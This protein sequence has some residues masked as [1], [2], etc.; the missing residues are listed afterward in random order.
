MEQKD[1]QMALPERKAPIHVFRE[2]G[3]TNDDAKRLAREGAVEG[4]T[5]I[6]ESQS[7]GRGRMG[8]SFSSP[9]GKGLYL[10]VIYRPAEMKLT[11]L[12]VFTAWAAVAV[13]R[14]LEKEL[15]CA[16][17]IKWTNDIL[18]G[19]RKVCGILTES[20]LCGDHAEFIVAG[21][22]LNLARRE[23]DFPEELRQI[24]T[25]T[26]LATG[27]ELKPE[28]AA[29]SLLRELDICY[30]EY[31]SGGGFLPEAYRARCVTVGQH[32]F[33]EEKCRRHTGQVTSLGDGGELIVRRD[34]GTETKI[35][36]GEVSVRPENDLCV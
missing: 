8:R 1:L 3:S 4:T 12:P 11:H 19:G 22:G 7:A 6:A 36:W 32:V 25:S 23:E 34:D 13:C 15:D 35:G 16:P 29:A 5:V 9:G 27:K 28:R 18:L 33:W 24:A 2:T 30:R 31:L 20:Q 17:Q 26:L 21:I 14:M 10:S